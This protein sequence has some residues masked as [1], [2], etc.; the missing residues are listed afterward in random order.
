MTTMRL[1]LLLQA[2]GRL[3]L[4]IAARRRSSGSTPPPTR[5]SPPTGRS[6]PSETGGA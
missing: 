3:I 1:V 6:G 2:L 5:S 4:D